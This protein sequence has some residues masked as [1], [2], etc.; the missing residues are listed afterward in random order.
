MKIKIQNT[1][2]DSNDEPIMII[3][4]N[5]D[6][7]NIQNMHPEATKYCSYPEYGYSTEQIAAFMQCQFIQSKNYKTK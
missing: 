6:K 4:S 7:E 1:I 5:E 2:Y 3:L